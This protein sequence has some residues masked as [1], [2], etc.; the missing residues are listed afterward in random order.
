[1]SHA[2]VMVPERPVAPAESPGLLTSFVVATL[3]TSL[4]AFAFMMALRSVSRHEGGGSLEGL[5][6]IYLIGGLFSPVAVALKGLVLAGLIWGTA[7]LFDCPV[8]FRNCVAA[9][10][11]AEPIL[12]APQLAAAANALAS[13]AQHR[14]ELSFP[15]G[16]DLFW[17]PE[18]PVLALLSHSANFAVVAWGVMLFLLLRQSSEA[19]RGRSWPL[20]VSV[21]V[22][23]AILVLYPVIQLAR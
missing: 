18:S 15:V 8:R 13:G 21:G 2:A 3:A 4:A 22:C 11:F 19:V 9:A 17:H 7:M 12:V 5:A 6:A 14:S 20:G 23:A 10:W 1:V 16:L